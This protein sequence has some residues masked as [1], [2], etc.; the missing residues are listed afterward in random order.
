[1]PVLARVVE[2]HGWRTGGG[3]MWF[4]YES[5]LILMRPHTPALPAAADPNHAAA[6]VEHV[7]LPKLPGRAAVNGVSTI[8]T[9]LHR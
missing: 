4:A 2:V 5:K 3:G 6:V 1:M 8:D 9:Q 7:V